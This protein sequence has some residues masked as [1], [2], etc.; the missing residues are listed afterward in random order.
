MYIRILL[1]SY[2]YIF[3][4]T[5]KK[6]TTPKIGSSS[7]SA[8][9]LHFRDIVKRYCARYSIVLRSANFR[10]NIVGCGDLGLSISIKYIYGR[11]SR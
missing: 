4:G 8:S 6:L 11:R 10:E 7:D 9:D 2:I 1:V 5:R 3:R